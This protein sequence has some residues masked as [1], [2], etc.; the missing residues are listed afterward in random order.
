MFP[1]GQVIDLHPYEPNE[2]APALMAAL[3]TDAPIIALHLT[4]PAIELPDR[5][6]LGMG[7]F[8]EAAKGAYLIRDYDPSR[9]KEGCVFVRGTSCTASVVELLKAGWFDSDGPNVKLVSAISHELFMLQPESYRN[10][11]I[12]AEDWANSTFI[13][14]NARQNMWLWTA[15]RA[16]YDYAMGPDHDQ[17]WRTG[18]SVDEI[19]AEAKLDPASIQEG[20]AR[21]VADY[22]KRMSASFVPA[23]L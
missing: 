17:R 13:T 8:R 20:L 3:G 1:R 6:A 16:S 14:N 4:R 23:A 5:A 7:D 9:P 2:V 21:F 12:S 22:D 18:G 11:L 19:I 15:N 10:E